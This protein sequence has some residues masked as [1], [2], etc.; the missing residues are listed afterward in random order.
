MQAW[1]K[2]IERRMPDSA[3]FD[4]ACGFLLAGGKSSRMGRDKALLKLDGEMLI[5]RGVRKLR[6][7]CA[8]VAIAGGTPDRWRFGRVISDGVPGLGPLG[9]IVAA[10]EQTPYEWN[11]FLAVDMP[12]VPVEALR[13][14]VA[15]AGGVAEMVVL[16]RAEGYV[17]PLCGVYSR[18]A[19]MALREELT[20]GR[21]KVKDAVAATGAVGYVEFADLGWFRNLNTPEEFR[22][23]TDA[24]SG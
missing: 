4:Y 12:F 9:G 22:T 24:L 1:E 2:I 5:A 13:A 19:L 23:A 6:R 8:E 17:Q 21:L 3:T 7:V 16:A 18:R 10:L 14:L 20:A 11:L 15:A